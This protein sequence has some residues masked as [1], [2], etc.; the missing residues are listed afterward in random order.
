[1]TFHFTI[2]TNKGSIKAELLDE[3]SNEL[4]GTIEDD[5]QLNIPKDST[6]RI[7]VIGDNHGGN[8]SLSWELS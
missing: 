4:I 3:D 7:K 6:Y 5:T 2:H 8:F 1:M